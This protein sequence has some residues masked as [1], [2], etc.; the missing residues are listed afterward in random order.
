MYGMVARSTFGNLAAKVCPEGQLNSLELSLRRPRECATRPPSRP[1]EELKGVLYLLCFS[2]D[3]LLINTFQLI[4]NKG[5]AMINNTF[6][7][8]GNIFH[9][10]CHTSYHYE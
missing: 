2:N 7:V 6:Y 9:G 10:R 8:V 1:S 5:L 4:S 3:R